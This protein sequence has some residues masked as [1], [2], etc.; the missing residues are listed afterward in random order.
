M[1][2]WVIRCAL[3][4]VFLGSYWLMYQHGRS[5]ERANAGLASAQRDSGDR[6]AEVIGERGARQE[7]HRRAQAQEEARAHAQE[8]R[9]IADAGAAGAD[10]A[11]QRLRDEAGKLAATISCPG[12]DTAAVARG[13][14]AT[15]AAMV[16]SELRDRADARAGELAKA[17]DRARIAG[18]ACEASY[19]ALIN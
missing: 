14:A 12:T 15:R 17:Y 6:L 3:L 16:L 7:E 1:K 11:G 5:V 2:S 18:L 9:T 19:N 8:E 10:V 4:L 13:Q